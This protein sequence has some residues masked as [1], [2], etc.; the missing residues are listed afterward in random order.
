MDPV[1]VDGLR[2][3]HKKRTQ[4]A[5]RDA[6]I[7]RFIRDGFDRTTVEDIAADV[8]VSPRTFFRYFPTKDAVVITPYVDLFVSWETI[9]RSATAGAALI[10]VLREASHAVTDAYASDAVFWDRHHEAVTTDPAIG[11]RMLQ[12][13]AQLQQRAAR[14]LSDVLGLDLRHDL[15]P[16]IIA[17]AAMAGVAAAVARWYASGQQAD[18]RKLIDAAYEEVATAG[19]LLSRP[20]P[21]RAGA[22]SATSPT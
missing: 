12:T 13:Q 3:R 14:A 4:I 8:D 6:A 21:S 19:E 16:H 7:R 18:R 20:I 1:P 15:R 17:A 11:T 2:A 9:V 5:L 22:S 10:D